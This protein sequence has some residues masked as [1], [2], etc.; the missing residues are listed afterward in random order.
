MTKEDKGLDELLEIVYDFVLNPDLSDDERKIGLLAKADLERGRYQIAVLNQIIAS[1][2]ILA[3][4]KKGLSSEAD[5]FYKKIYALLI[6]DKPIGTNIGYM[7]ING[8]YLS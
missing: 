1:F 4:E 6:K 8:S 5:K 2:Q 7:G 3:V